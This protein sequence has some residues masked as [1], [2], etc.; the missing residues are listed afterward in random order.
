MLKKIFI[1]TISIL[2]SIKV[3]SSITSYYYRMSSENQTDTNATTSPTESSLTSTQNA[4]GTTIQTIQVPEGERYMAIVKWF[5]NSLN[6]GFATILSGDHVNKDIFVHQSNIL[7]LNTNIYRTLRMGE[8]IEFAL[9]ATDSTEHKFQAV[10][11]TGPSAGILMC[12]SNPGRRN[13]TTHN[14]VQPRTNRGFNSNYNGRGQGTRRFPQYN[15]NR[16]RRRGRSN[17]PQ[18]IENTDDCTNN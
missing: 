10:A 8:Y 2:T 4:A 15:P 12:E 5:D 13:N 17:H 3:I 14:G 6:Y 11:V 16:G 1:V 9:E 18:V 7:T